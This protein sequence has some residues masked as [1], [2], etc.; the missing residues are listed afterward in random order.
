VE[1]TPLSTAAIRNH[2]RR[3]GEEPPAFLSKPRTPAA[4]GT[5]TSTPPSPRRP[6]GARRTG[7]ATRQ[8]TFDAHPDT[9]GEQAARTQGLTDAFDHFQQFVDE[10][11]YR[12][13]RG[14]GGIRTKRTKKDADQVAR[15]LTAN[16]DGIEWQAVRVNPFGASKE[17]LHAMLEGT[18]PHAPLHTADEGARRGRRGGTVGDR[19]ERPRLTGCRSTSGS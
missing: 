3:H 10:F 17:Q 18:E 4:P 5:S 9:L 19:P 2:M 15:D 16:G 13:P 12:D 14:R 8:G 1:D 7:E 11:G 6:P